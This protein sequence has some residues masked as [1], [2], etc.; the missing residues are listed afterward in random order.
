ME[1]KGGLCSLCLVTALY[2]EP[3]GGR[4]E[5]VKYGFRESRSG[6]ASRWF[7]L[8][9]EDKKFART[10]IHVWV[11]VLAQLLATL[12]VCVACEGCSS[13]TE[14]YPTVYPRAYR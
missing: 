3:Q 8:K 6:K 1:T 5:H 7:I 12:L 13:F 2:E 10:E 9:T 11:G 14:S 4:R